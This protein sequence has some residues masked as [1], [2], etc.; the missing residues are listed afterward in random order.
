MWIPLHQGYWLPETRII[1]S[2]TR[3]ERLSRLRTLMQDR[4]IK[5]YANC[6]TYRPEPE[7]RLYSCPTLYERPIT[8]GMAM[9]MNDSVYNLLASCQ[10]EV[11]TEHRA[12][13]LDDISVPEKR[14]EP[15]MPTNYQILYQTQYN[16][17]SMSKC[18]PCIAVFSTQQSVHEYRNGHMF[19]GGLAIPRTCPRRELLPVSMQGECK[20]CFVT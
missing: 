18:L 9:S 20:F 19:Y 13:G 3:F 14:I 4:I 1:L 16:V 5:Q 15:P 17:L 6:G 11:Q 2:F 12:L 7:T 8:T 10:P